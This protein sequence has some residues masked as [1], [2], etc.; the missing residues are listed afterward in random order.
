MTM[1]SVRE[2][3]AYFVAKSYQDGIPVTHLKLQK[4]LYYAQ[5]W[6]LAFLGRPLFHE[7][8][9]AW[10]F[11]SVIPDVY[12]RL[13]KYGNSN[14]PRTSVQVSF[15]KD[16][17]ELLDGVW[18]SY[19]NMTEADLSSRSLA[20]E[21]PW[22][23]IMMV[24]GGSDKIPDHTEI[25]VVSMMEYFKNLDN[26]AKASS[27]CLRITEHLSKSGFVPNSYKLE[28]KSGG[29]YSA[30]FIVPE[31]KYHSQKMENVHEFVFSVI[32]ELNND[33]Y[34]L[35]VHFTFDRNP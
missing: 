29:T 8:I 27:A 32:D 26:K 31:D 14:I 13:K 35:S 5:G 4:W 9:E 30:E 1:K 18:S 22:M 6:H 25:S 7:R 24:Y 15:D 23:K 17:L 2:A 20:K 34:H 28:Y 10:R 16:S 12:D 11:G 19:K 33:S 21:S 3:C